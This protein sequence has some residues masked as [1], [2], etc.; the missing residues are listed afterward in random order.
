ML[1]LL[2]QSAFLDGMVVWRQD[3]GDAELAALYRGCRFTLFPSLYEGWGLP[4]AESLCFGKPCLAA[5]ASSVPEIG[6]SLVDYFD[7]LDLHDALR[8]IEAALADP[9]MLADREDAIRANFRP[10]PWTDT[11]AQLLAGLTVQSTT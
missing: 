10:T 2:R 1:S 5:N 6:G 7:P 11:A 8:V 9:A 3:C 4:V